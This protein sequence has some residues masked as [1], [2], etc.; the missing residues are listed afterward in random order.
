MRTLLRPSLLYTT[1][2]CSTV[3]T[4]WKRAARSSSVYAQGIPWTTICT[5]TYSIQRAAPMSLQLKM[6]SYRW[7]EQWHRAC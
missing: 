4:S 3:P 5:Y 2:A 7:S 6:H 1:L